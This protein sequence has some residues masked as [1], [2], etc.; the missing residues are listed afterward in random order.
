LVLRGI[1]RAVLKRTACRRPTG[2]W[3][4]SNEIVYHALTR[5]VLAHAKVH[6]VLSIIG[7]VV[8]RQCPW[9]LPLKF[10]TYFPPK[11]GISMSSKSVSI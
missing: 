8:A 6:S 2:P 11:S 1:H 10:A 9:R 5:F 3:A 4:L 7:T